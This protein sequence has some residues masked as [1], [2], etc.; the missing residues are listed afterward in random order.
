MDR[1]D[2]R[3]EVGCCCYLGVVCSVNVVACVCECVVVCDEK[4]TRCEHER[5]ILPNIEA[6]RPTLRS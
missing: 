3:D 4:E 5:C 1:L 2:V 6:G